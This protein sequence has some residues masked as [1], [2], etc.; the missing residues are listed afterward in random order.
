MKVSGCTPNRPRAH[1][2]CFKAPLFPFAESSFLRL[3]L[4]ILS[5]RTRQR[6]G[7]ENKGERY[8][9]L[10]DDFG[11]LKLE[12]RK[13]KVA[14]SG[15]FQVWDAEA[16]DSPDL[17]SPV[18]LYRTTKKILHNNILHTHKTMDRTLRIFRETTLQQAKSIAKRIFSARDAPDDA[19]NH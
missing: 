4:R 9:F 17:I 2:I 3:R 1:R 10:R 8:C 13:N 12:E 15:K 18:Y 14:F 11:C 7:S 6:Y 5:I 19:G 16:G